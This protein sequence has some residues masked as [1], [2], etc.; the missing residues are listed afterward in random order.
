MELRIV[1]FLAFISITLITNTLLIWLAYKAFSGVTTKVT[2]AVFQL[3]TSSE[4]KE[5]ITRL[6]SASEQ[7]L[8]LT[9][10]AKVKLAEFEPVIKSARQ[11][12]RETMARV[13]STLETVADEITT[14]ARKMRDVVSK[15]AFS[16]L[17]FAATLSQ[18][19]QSMETE[20]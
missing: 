8:S 14:T 3:E 18:F 6:Q 5:W 11:H 13:D 17:A 9:V 19:L 7:A 20:E 4:R 16:V 2:E 10:A 1:I 12:H 15:P